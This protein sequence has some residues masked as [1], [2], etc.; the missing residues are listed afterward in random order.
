M[1]NLC[2]MIVTTSSFSWVAS[3]RRFFSENLLWLMMFG[4]ISKTIFFFGKPV[5]VDDVSLKSQ[6]IEFSHHDVM[7]CG[8]CR[9][10]SDAEA[11]NTNASPRRMA[12]MALAL[13]VA[14]VGG[15]GG[16]VVRWSKI[17]NE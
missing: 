11:E 1:H 7:V 16:G 10:F 5:V 12:A 13:S 8:C 9:L 14:S 17:L 15:Q 3:L 6:Y 2:K 4:G